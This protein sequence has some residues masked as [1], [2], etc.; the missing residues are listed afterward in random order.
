VH[1]ANQIVANASEDD[2]SR[3]SPQAI[4]P[5]YYFSLATHANIRDYHLFPM[6]VSGRP[7]KIGWFGRFQHLGADA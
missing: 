3:N 7:R 2:H 4:I 5:A 1:N 6:M